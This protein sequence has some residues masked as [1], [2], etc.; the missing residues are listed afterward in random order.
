MFVYETNV[1]PNLNLSNDI[2]SGKHFESEAIKLIIGY[3]FGT[4]ASYSFTIVAKFTIGRLRPH[5]LDVCRPNFQ[6][7]RTF[8]TKKL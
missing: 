2:I 3:M 5:F 7:C 8:Q 1:I 4:C 6:G